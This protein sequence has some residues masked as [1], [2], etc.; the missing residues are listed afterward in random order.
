[1][2]SKLC[3]PTLE[4]WKKATDELNTIRKDVEKRN[5]EIGEI[6][7]KLEEVLIVSM[8]HV[9]IMILWLTR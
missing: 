2:P 3:L 7:K 6:K 9:Y 1:M 5:K 4:E 8:P